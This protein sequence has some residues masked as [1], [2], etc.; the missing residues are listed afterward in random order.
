MSSDSE[1]L[2]EVI[3]GVDILCLSCPECA[4]NR[5]ESP[6]GNEEEVRKWDVKALKGLGISYGERRTAK[7][8]RELVEAKAPLEFCRTRCPWKEVCKVFDLL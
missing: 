7:A 8:F 5:C 3:E 4:G 6:H 2:I 1:A